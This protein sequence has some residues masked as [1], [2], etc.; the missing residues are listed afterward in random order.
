MVCMTTSP[1]KKYEVCV[2][3]SMWF[4]VSHVKGAAN[5]GFVKSVCMSVYWSVGLLDCWTVGLLVC[6][7]VS[8]SVC[9]LANNWYQQF[10][11]MKSVAAYNKNI[12]TFLMGI[13][14]PQWHHVCY[15]CQELHDW[16]SQV[17]V[18]K[19]CI[20][21]FGKCYTSFFMYS[22][23]IVIN[24]CSVIACWCLN[25]CGWSMTV[26]Q[27]WQQICDAWLMSSSDESG[28]RWIDWPHSLHSEMNDAVSIILVNKVLYI[29]M[30][31]E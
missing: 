10:M 7:S 28:L 4:C 31:T 19:W 18:I 2:I 14:H 6:Q 26:D 5:W 22:R 11:S 13:M 23:S 20:L 3:F 12:L 24:T 9:W 30:Y 8:L 1:V 25:E 15:L 27:N 29:E 17:L 16:T 21:L